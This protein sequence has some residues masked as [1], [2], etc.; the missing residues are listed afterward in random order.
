MVLCCSPF[1][2]VHR[3]NQRQDSL[4]FNLLTQSWVV[5]IL[6]QILLLRYIN[7]ML[8]FLQLILDPMFGWK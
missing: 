5:V 3:S 8:D 2:V 6:V 1:A 4:G 7:V